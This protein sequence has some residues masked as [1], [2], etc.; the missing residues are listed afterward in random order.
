[1]K[2]SKVFTTVLACSFLLGVGLATVAPTVGV[3]RL[4][5]PQFTCDHSCSAVF[6]GGQGSCPYGFVEKLECGLEP[7]C[8]PGG[9]PCECEVIGCS[10]PL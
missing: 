3:A 8:R 1:M 2:M 9:V 5:P 4:E 7:F 10:F 6:T